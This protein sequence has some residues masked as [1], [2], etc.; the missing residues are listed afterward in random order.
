MLYKYHLDSFLSVRK[1][2]KAECGVFPLAEYQSPLIDEAAVM[3]KDLTR[4]VPLIETR[5]SVI[6]DK[7]IILDFLGKNGVILC[8]LSVVS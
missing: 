4:V 5:Q 7:V 6:E 3:R 1:L 2:G 8:G